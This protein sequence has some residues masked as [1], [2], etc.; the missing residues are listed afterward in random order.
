MFQ[1]PVLRIHPIFDDRALNVGECSEYPSEGVANDF[2]IF[3]QEPV[4]AKFVEKGLAARPIAG[5]DVR[6]YAAKASCCGWGVSG[7]M[8]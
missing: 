7:H 6:G 3:I 1:P 2:V 8:G 4:A 5:E